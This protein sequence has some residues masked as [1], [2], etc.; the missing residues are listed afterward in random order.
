MAGKAAARAS[1]KW[2]RRSASRKGSDEPPHSKPADRGGETMKRPW[3]AWWAS[4]ARVRKRPF[5]LWTEKQNTTSGFSSM[6]ERQ[7]E[8]DGRVPAGEANPDKDL[9][10]RL[11]LPVRLALPALPVR[12]NGQDPKDRAAFKIHVPLSSRFPLY[13]Y[14]NRRSS[15]RRQA[16]R[17]SDLSPRPHTGAG[18]AGTGRSLLFI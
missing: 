10:A 11:E 9:P 15:P 13:G 5:E 18:P 2:S 7:G 8:I 17:K 12:A 1:N 3:G 4:S 16:S 14:R 6:P